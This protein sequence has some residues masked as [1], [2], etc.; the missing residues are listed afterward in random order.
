MGSRDQLTL[1]CLSPSDFS[2]FSCLQHIG[3]TELA[4]RLLNTPLF[5][6]YSCNCALF[7]GMAQFNRNGNALA[8]F[9]C[10]GQKVDKRLMSDEGDERHRA[11]MRRSRM[12]V[13][14]LRSLKPGLRQSVMDMTAIRLGATLGSSRAGIDASLKLAVAKLS[15]AK[16]R[17]E[18]ISTDWLIVETILVCLELLAEPA[19]LRR[20]EQRETT[21][22]LQVLNELISRHTSEP[23]LTALRSAAGWPFNEA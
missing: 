20:E 19:G 8:S 15:S 6:T 22:Q 16:S 23:P 12:V 7:G 11:L 9:T 13:G 10:D 17:L 4:S 21:E 3:K 18:P 14:K 5:G 2:G 1:P